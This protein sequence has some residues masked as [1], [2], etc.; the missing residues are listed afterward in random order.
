MDRHIDLT[1]NRDFRQRRVDPSVPRSIFSK[2]KSLGAHLVPTFGAGMNV[3]SNGW[4]TNGTIMTT[5]GTFTN[6]SYNN[7]YGYKDD[8]LCDRC[9]KDISRIP[10]NKA[11]HYNLCK[12]CDTHI[13]EKIIPWK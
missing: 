11:I 8:G 5:G 10:W 2:D 1:R 7:D 12:E 6:F 4:F 9:G 3:S 13:S